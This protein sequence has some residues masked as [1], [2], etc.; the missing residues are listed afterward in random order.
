MIILSDRFFAMRLL[1]LSSWR[2]RFVG[3]LTALVFIVLFVYALVQLYGTVAG[4]GA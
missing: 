3:W 4:G 2:W 1:F